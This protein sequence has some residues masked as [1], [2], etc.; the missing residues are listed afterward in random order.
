MANQ[1]RDLSRV[2]EKETTTQKASNSGP[3][4]R[5]KAGTMPARRADRK[6]GSKP[7]IG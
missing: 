1:D 4:A 7:K 6:G 2:S 3:T 5:M